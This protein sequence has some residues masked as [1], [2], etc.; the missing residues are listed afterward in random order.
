MYVRIRPQITQIAQ[1]AAAPGGKAAS[2]KRQIEITSLP[3]L[4]CWLVISICLS[5]RSRELRS[6]LAPRCVASVPSVKSV[7]AFNLRRVGP[8][9]VA[10]TMLASVASAQSTEGSGT[11]WLPDETPMRMIHASADGW[12]LMTHFNV[13]AQ[14][15]HD[16][17]DRGSSQAGSINWLM[18]MAQ[19]SGAG[20]SFTVRGMVSAEPLTIGG[21][22]YPDLLATGE[23]CDGEAIHDR[24]HPHD[25]VMEVAVQY[26]RPLAKGVRLQLYGGPAGEPAL[27]PVAFMHRISGFANPLAPIAHHWLDSTHV[28]YGVATA[29]FY[30]G[31]WKIEGSVFNGREP[32]ED[33][34]GLDLAAMDSWSGR[35]WF[36]PA[37]R[38][39][40]Q[41]SA[42][43]LHDA[44][45]IT[46]SASYH[47][48][49][50]NGLWAS[51]VAWGQ[52]RETGE[53][54]NALLAETNLSPS[55]H[56]AIYGRI[57]WVEK[58][59]HD[60]ALEG[61]DIFDVVKMQ[62]GYTRFTSPWKKVVAG[63]GASVTAG[64]VPSGLESTYG[65]RFN[66]GLSVYLNL[67]PG[68]R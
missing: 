8:I 18:L 24:Q 31:K 44:D 10:L 48:P 12:M 61:D 50:A 17:G 27:G 6:R 64:I 13:F 35:A 41:V 9:I 11:S 15:L 26:D 22:G 36:L 20:G 4:P 66:P 55:D 57:E 49:L 59:A 38:W 54:T 51:T 16:S 45:R 25:L 30:A 60:L 2:E 28:T 19:R 46:A 33:R 29:G 21:C 63:I 62:T 37:S 7:D 14:Y 43:R 1:T 42:G 5:S 32:D 3:R 68:H 40:L 47:R 52:N 23:V 53:S 58:S 65:R 34:V 67:M 56:H 39:A